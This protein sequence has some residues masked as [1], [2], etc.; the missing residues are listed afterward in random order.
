M[1]AP[2]EAKLVT[3]SETNAH[4]CASLLLNMLLD[5]IEKV[6]ADWERHRCYQVDLGSL[7]V[8]LGFFL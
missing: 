5:G 2:D 4:V 8:S 6:R 3:V 7:Q 1:G